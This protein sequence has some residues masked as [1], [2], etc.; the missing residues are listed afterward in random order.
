[1]AK[2]PVYFSDLPV[3]RKVWE[4]VGGAVVTGVVCGILLGV[5]WWAY[6]IAVVMTFVGGA[7]AGTQ[8]HTLGGAALRGFTGGAVWAGTVL[9]VS[10]A[11]RLTP[12]VAFPDP[13]IAFL[14]WGIIPATIVAMITWAIAHRVRTRRRLSS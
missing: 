4:S 8:H 13:S 2:P 3:G 1:M 10:A 6:L 11:S 9:L 14:L 7:P 5:T 12:T